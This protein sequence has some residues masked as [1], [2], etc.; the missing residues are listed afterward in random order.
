M[1]MTQLPAAHPAKQ[2]TKT[3]AQKG[4]CRYR[5]EHKI[6]R[7]RLCACYPLPSRLVWCLRIGMAVALMLLARPAA[8]LDVLTRTLG[9][10]GAWVV[11][12][13]L[14]CSHPHK[15]FLS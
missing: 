15:S 5:P 6:V 12:L 3:V 11:V 10:L 14:L 1:A 7:S 13:V 8:G 9:D 4:G 2:L